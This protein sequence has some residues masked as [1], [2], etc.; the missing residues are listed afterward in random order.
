MRLRPKKFMGQNFLTNPK[1]IEQ[2]LMAVKSCKPEGIMEIGPGL[3]ALTTPLLNL[4]KP[5]CL[6]EKDKLLAKYWRDKLNTLTKKNQLEQKTKPLNKNFFNVIEGDVLKIPFANYF[7]PNTI[8]TGNLPYQVAG[9]LI[10]ECCPGAKELKAMVLMCQQEV[11]EKI[12]ASRKS[13]NYG[14]LSVLCQSFW[15]VSIVVKAKTTDFYP[16]P[17]VQGLVLKFSNKKKPVSNPKAFLGFVKFCFSE[18][19]KILLSRLKKQQAKYSLNMV[20]IFQ[21]LELNPKARPEELSIKQF[22]ALFTATHKLL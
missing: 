6:I 8:L 5:L 11:G 19:R 7:K 20:D 4:K 1:V 17:K 15:Q 21:K 2:T 22:T 14:L 13:K 18:R 10:L 12:L 9:R 16:Q 3:G